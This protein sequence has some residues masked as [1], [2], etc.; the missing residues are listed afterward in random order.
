MTPPRAARHRHIWIP[1]IALPAILVML[2]ASAC[3]TGDGPVGT[4]DS[5]GGP[6]SYPAIADRIAEYADT[7]AEDDQIPAVAIGIITPDGLAEGRYLGANHAG[8]PVTGG[9]L[10]EIGSATKAFLGVTQAILVDR[11]ELAWDDRVVDHYPDFTLYD[12]WVTREFRIADLLAQRTGMPEYS[13]DEMFDFG[14]PWADNVPAMADVE[15]ESSFRSE[16]AYQNNPHYVAGEI[17]ADKIGADDWNAAVAELIFDPL[18][19]TD[20]GTGKTALVDAPDTTRGHTLREGAVHEQPLA[21]FPSVSQGA[22][23]IVS[24]LDD[25]A[26]WVSVHLSGG[27]GPDGRLISEEQLDETY[28]TRVTVTEDYFTRLVEMGPDR[29]DIGYATG[30]VVHS[31]PEGRVIEHGGITLGYNSAVMFDPDRRVG[32]VVLTNQGYQ[33][34]SATSI[35]KYGMDLLQGRE[36]RDYFAESEAFR[37]ETVAEGAAA[38]RELIDGNT[39]AE[40]PLD[41]YVGVYEHPRLGRLNFRADG[42]VLTTQLGPR[43]FDATASRLAGSIFTL[44]WRIEGDPEA[45]LHEKI[46]TFDDSGDRPD[47]VDVGGLVFDRI[48]SPD[49]QVR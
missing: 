26:T 38:T 18:G 35:G 45:G 13:A 27:D 17:V 24:T 16:F 30:W 12:P 34:G 48:P 33:G 39:S 7:V 31:M 44:T 36:P 20:S 21:D 14:Y 15:P 23:S 3:S 2:L 47:H 40:H 8:E 42:D 49:D 9:T 32:L 22:G 6:E 41:W 43:D 46:T 4:A 10:F 29:P 19:M 5:T 1:T 37:E 11:G 25:L 28:R